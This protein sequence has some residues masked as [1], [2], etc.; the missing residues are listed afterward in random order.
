MKPVMLH[1]RGATLVT[2]LILLLVMTM[3]GLAGVRSTVLQERMT[4][5]SY[6]RNIAFQAT[7]TALLEGE[8]FAKTLPTP[9]S[10]GCATVVSGGRSG[11]IC[12]RP[13]AGAASRWTDQTVWSAAQAITSSLV[14]TGQAAGESKFFV[15]IVADYVPFNPDDCT[16][17][18][19]ISVKFCEGNER[20]YRVTA[21][22]QAADR[23]AVILQSIYSVP[24]D[25]APATP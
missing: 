14:E 9:P 17:G 21:R 24:L 15:E 12:A 23:A 22:S 6:D 20:R 4:A 8:E 13:T 1:Q 2:V 19:D 5:G 18:I 11:R 7:E 10:S 16:T 25:S 3:L